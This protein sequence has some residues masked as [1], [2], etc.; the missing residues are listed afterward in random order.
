MSVLKLS[1]PEPPPGMDPTAY[2]RSFADP[3]AIGAFAE[4]SKAAVRIPFGDVDTIELIRIR[5]AA[6]HSCEY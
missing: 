4:F 3:S 1:I 6:V 5:N 2:F